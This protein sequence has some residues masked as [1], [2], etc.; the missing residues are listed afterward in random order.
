MVI[1]GLTMSDALTMY[2]KNACWQP[3]L[4][5]TLLY[6]NKYNLG[7]MVIPG[8]HERASRIVYKDNISC[9]ALLLGKSSSMSLH[10]ET[11][12]F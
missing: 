7:T 9:L 2:G 12:R 6:L 3:T 11:Y 5:V 8:N 1:V 10:H 4:D